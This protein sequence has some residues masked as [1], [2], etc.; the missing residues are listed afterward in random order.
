MLKKSD[1]T[2]QQTASNIAVVNENNISFPSTS[3]GPYYNQVVPVLQAFP[4]DNVESHAVDMTEPYTR[5]AVA[6]QWSEPGWND[7]QAAVETPNVQI[8]GS[9]DLTTK[10]ARKNAVSNGKSCKTKNLKKCRHCDR[11][12]WSHTGRYYHE[13][14]H[15]GKWLFQCEFCSAG[16]MQRKA[17]DSHVRAKHRGQPAADQN[18]QENA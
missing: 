9:L 7:H 8:V 18:D 11:T 12:F 1:A 3:G 14:I 16:F 17:Y 6:V 15:T 4:Y 10:D 2:V 5:A 13:A